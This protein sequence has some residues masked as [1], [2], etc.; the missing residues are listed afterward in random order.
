LSPTERV[1]QVRR[2]IAAQLG[3]AEILQLD[4]DSHPIAIL[5]KTAE[6]PTF[7]FFQF[8]LTPV[9]AETLQPTTPKQAKDIHDE[10]PFQRILPNSQIA[11][12]LWPG[13]PSQAPARKTNK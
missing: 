11:F 1:L 13:D 2:N 10:T 8:A 9:H 6:L 7:V 5:S 12:L 3:V 4:C